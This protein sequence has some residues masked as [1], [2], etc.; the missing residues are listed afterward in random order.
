[1]G[2]TMEICAYTPGAPGW[3]A[4]A[5]YAAGCS[6]R[7]G[8]SMADWMRSGKPLPWERCF[9]ALEQGRFRGFCTLAAQDCIPELSYTPYVGYV[10]VEED[11]RGCRL[12]QRLIDAALRE[13]ARL[14]YRAAYLVS[15]HAGLY[16]KYGFTPVDAA[17]APWN[18]AQVETIFRYDLAGGQR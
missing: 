18:P 14:G 15:D 8:R 10:F 16:E 7:A 5:D 3:D 1:M 17:P 13:A 4:L 6:W 9:A 11:A 12:S 2:D